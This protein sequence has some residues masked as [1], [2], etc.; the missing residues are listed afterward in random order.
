MA[1]DPLTDGLFTLWHNV[2]WYALM[3][4]HGGGLDVSFSG[5]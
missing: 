3:A 5:Q 1:C 4:Y 2:A